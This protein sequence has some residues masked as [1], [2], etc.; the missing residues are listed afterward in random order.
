MNLEQRINDSTTNSL[1]VE[2][3]EKHRQATECAS[4]AVQLAREAGD[5]LIQAKAALPHGQ[6]GTWVK[7]NCDLSERTAQSYMRLSREIPKLDGAKAQRVADLPLRQ[8]LKELAAS[9]EP[10]P[11]P[12][13]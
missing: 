12:L 6:W 4:Q 11:S 3:R 1:A 9:H 13:R 10:A 5:L 2:I 7:E 8:A